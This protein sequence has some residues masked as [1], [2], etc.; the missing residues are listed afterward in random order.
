MASTPTQELLIARELE[1]I[2]TQQMMQA[3]RL[4]EIA[5]MI[6]RLDG[7]PTQEIPPLLA[8]AI[9]TP[10]PPG[11]M[12]VWL[13]APAMAR[14]R[15]SRL[16]VLKIWTR[17]KLESHTDDILTSL[18]AYGES[19]SWQQEGGKFIPALHRWLGKRKYE[20]KPPPTP[21]EMMM[22]QMR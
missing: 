13:A 9:E 10:Y 8:Q 18:E 16:D 2:A 15:S 1:N 22:E 3:K 5:S 17:D 6:R 19:D 4:R 14:S 12:R 7:H 21:E 20:E 11:L